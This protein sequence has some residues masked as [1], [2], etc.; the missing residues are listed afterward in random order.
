MS[1]VNWSPDAQRLLDKRTVPTRPL[2][3]YSRAVSLVGAAPG[4][5]TPVASSRPSLYRAA[6]SARPEVEKSCS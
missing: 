2:H 3:V 1:R 6:D 5:G 4:P